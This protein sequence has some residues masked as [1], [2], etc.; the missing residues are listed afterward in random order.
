M[1]NANDIAEW[2]IERILDE[3]TV[4][5]EHIVHDLERKFGTEWVYQNE[6]GNPAINKT[7]LTK[8]RKLHEGAIEWDR[9]DRCWTAKKI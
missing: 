1:T 6:N 5:Q 2:L 4:Y 9:S 8:F 7:V 3:K